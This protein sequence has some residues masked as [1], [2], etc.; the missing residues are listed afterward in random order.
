MLFK[1][2]MKINTTDII[3]PETIGKEASIMN[4]KKITTIPQE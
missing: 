3:T 1:Q 4:L 2:I